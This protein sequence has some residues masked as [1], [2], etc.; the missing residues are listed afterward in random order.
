MRQWLKEKRTNQGFTQEDVAELA[1]VARTTYAMIEQGE[2]DPSVST[3]K[4]IAQ[5]LNFKWTIFFDDS[6]RESCSFSKEVS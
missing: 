3:A 4:K 2:R 6:V 1:G 5:T